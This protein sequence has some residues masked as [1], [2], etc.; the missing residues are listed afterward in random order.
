MTHL[1]PHNPVVA[2]LSV[3]LSSAQSGRRQAL[4][5]RGGSA[6][7]DEATPSCSPETAS[8]LALLAVTR[9]VSLA[10]QRPTACAE[11]CDRKATPLC[12][13]KDTSSAVR[14][15]LCNQETTSLFLAMN[16]TNVRIATKN[17]IRAL[18]NPARH[19]FGTPISTEK[20]RGN[21]VASVVICVDL[22]PPGRAEP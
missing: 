22:C 11:H 15:R 18:V 2:S 7:S 20:H 10:A 19:P 9:S 1:A 12:P 13:S 14:D 6:A 4:S 3:A 17:R 5:S 8:S 16:R 21:P